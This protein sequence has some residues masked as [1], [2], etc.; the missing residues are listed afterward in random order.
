MHSCV[1]LEKLDIFRNLSTRLNCFHRNKSLML[2][3]LAT[4][5]PEHKSSSRLFFPTNN[6]GS[7][8]WISCYQSIA[9]FALGNIYG[10]GSGGNY[11]S[12]RELGWCLLNVF[13]HS[14][15]NWPS[16]CTS[17]TDCKALRLKSLF[18]NLDFFALPV[19]TSTSVCRLVVFLQHTAI[20]LHNKCQI[21]CSTN[22]YIYIYFRALL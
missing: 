22:R 5:W 18:C 2:C 4:W 10:S 8:P 16:A 19:F 7:W 21:A 9:F 3:E 17:T 11:A 1:E 12:T 20:Y 6:M 13:K 14:R 15:F